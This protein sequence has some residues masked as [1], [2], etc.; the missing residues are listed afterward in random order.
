MKK[1]DQKIINLIIKAVK[2][3]EQ[4]HSLYSC[5]EE[6]AEE[7]KAFYEAKEKAYSLAIKMLDGAK[8][9]A[10]HYYK[11]A[12]NDQ[13][14][15][16]SVLIYFQ[17]KEA[18]KLFQFSF[19]KPLHGKAPSSKGHYIYWSETKNKEMLQQYAALHTSRD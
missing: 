7:K 14:G 10:I 15:Y 17:W 2:S 4:A 6:E 1:Y 18:G 11:C 19:H 8:H 13:N 3:N 5:F 9:S 12:T 16:P